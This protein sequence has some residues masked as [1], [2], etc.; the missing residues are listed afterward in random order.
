M[1]RATRQLTFAAIACTLLS[2]CEQQSRGFVL[3]PG[4]VAQGKTTFVALQCNGCHR[5][6]GAVDKLIEGG[7]PTIDV[8]IG[9]PTTRV[10]TYGDLV[11][12]IINPSH[13]ISGGFTPASSNADNTSRMRVYND[14]MTV[15]QLVDLTTFLQTTYSLVVPEYHRYPAR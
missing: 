4:D 12:S 3:P 13:R 8:T 10:N 6:P 5:I 9:G 1:H 15:Q 14:V 11:T 2:A 7:D